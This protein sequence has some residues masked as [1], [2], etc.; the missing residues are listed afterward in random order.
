MWQLPRFITWFFNSRYEKAF[1]WICVV[2][3][4]PVACG[5]ANN[6]DVLIKFHLQLVERLLDSSLYTKDLFIEEMLKY[7]PKTNYTYLLAFLTKAFSSMSVSVYILFI[8]S[9]S[10]LLL[11]FRA[12]GKE[13]DLSFFSY[14]VLVGW[15]F[16]V[17][18]GIT[19]MEPVTIGGVRFVQKDPRP[20]MI[21][22]SIAIWAWVLALKRK[23]ISCYAVLGLSSLFHVIVG[24]VGGVVLLPALI[25]N[26]WNNRDWRR[27]LL[28]MFCWGLG[29]AAIYIPTKLLGNTGTGLLS[30]KE[31]SNVYAY[32]A[33]R[34]HLVPSTWG[35]VSWINFILFYT[36][37]F[38]CLR[39]TS[40]LSSNVKR[41][42]V[43][44]VGM[45]GLMLFVNYLFIEILPV[46]IVSIFQLARMTTFSGVSILMLLIALFESFFR[47]K[48]WVCCTIVAII[49]VTIYAG[50]SMLLFALSLRFIRNRNTHLYSLFLAALIG[51]HFNW[52]FPIE[53]LYHLLQFLGVVTLLIF[54]IV[55]SKL[56]K[57]GILKLGINGLILLFSVISINLLSSSGI[58]VLLKKYL[59]VD[60]T[61]ASCA[62]YED[63]KKIAIEFAKKS[64]KDA[65][66]LI[67]PSYSQHLFSYFS[68]R[69]V[70]VDTDLAFTDKGIY[71]W[72]NRLSN[73]LEQ[74]IIKDFYVR[75]DPYR[76]VESVY[77]S[78]SESSIV[79][80]AKMY[81]AE[82]VLT[83]ASWHPDME[84]SIVAEY[85][86]WRVWK[87]L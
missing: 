62:Q 28:S 54:P 72:H 20:D 49:P 3:G 32:A 11:G 27:F 15:I 10:S 1:L 19:N 8:A 51:F 86:D 44:T 77:A 68:K 23:W 36:A 69:S 38:F 26:L 30:S 78:F 7:N 84:G 76:Q 22:H 52:T 21:A 83:K 47:E 41:F 25:V 56:L 79:A 40:L 34:G 58:P 59:N 85:D 71:E 70:V 5:Y 65:L 61:S 31:M 48:R 53:K 80:K 57:P 18:M 67:P 75:E 42:I 63:K 13:L 73:I 17:S 9:I 6:S 16:F 81:D 45:T 82:Y 74:D 66:I 12:L 33:H 87:L 14:A 37:C 29:L 35:I 46:G 2:L 43:T 50:A 39:H 24:F 60:L 55:Y 4:I 64:P